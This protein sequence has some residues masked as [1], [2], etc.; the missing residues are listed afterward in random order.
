[1]PCQGS[2]RYFGLSLRQTAVMFPAFDL[3]DSQ[4]G[5]NYQTNPFWIFVN[6]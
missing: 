4:K 6:W 1:M 2:E 5:Q 3:L